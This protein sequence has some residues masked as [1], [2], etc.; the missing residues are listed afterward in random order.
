VILLHDGG[1]SRVNTVAAVA[2][3]I[4]FYRA[5]GY[6]FTDVYGRSFPASR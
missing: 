3:V 1:G 2:A 6:R 4:D 5:H